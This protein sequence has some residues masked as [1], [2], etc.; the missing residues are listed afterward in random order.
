MLNKEQIELLS[1]EGRI[2]SENKIPNLLVEVRA[3]L[4]RSWIS[5]DKRFLILSEKIFDDLEGYHGSEIRSDQPRYGFFI[6]RSKYLPYKNIDGITFQ[7]KCE[8]ENC[9][10]NAEF[11]F[12]IVPGSIVKLKYE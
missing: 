2:I 1:T 11:I 10:D 12:N 3:D 4:N 8:L 6:Y 9:S 5:M 7:L